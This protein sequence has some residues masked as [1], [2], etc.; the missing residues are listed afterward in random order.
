MT[1]HMPGLTLSVALAACRRAQTQGRQQSLSVM[2]AKNGFD[3]AL[4]MTHV[5]SHCLAKWCL[6]ETQLEGSLDKN[7][8]NYDSEEDKTVSYH[9]QK[10]LQIKLY[11][12]AV[13][14][15]CVQQCVCRVVCTGT[16]RGPA[17]QAL[18]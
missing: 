4:G 3:I 17:A 12:K 18:H 1:L 6:Q 13:G 2:A 15:V 14:P 16:G 9:S 11:K 8:P 5:L 10:T 7:D